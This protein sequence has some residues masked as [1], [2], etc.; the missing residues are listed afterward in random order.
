MAKNRVYISC[1]SCQHSTILVDSS[2]RRVA[3]CGLNGRQYRIEAGTPY[4]TWCE[5]VKA[6]VR[7]DEDDTNHNGADSTRTV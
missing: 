6:K 1:Y 2:N 3:V 5:R 4:P 7:I